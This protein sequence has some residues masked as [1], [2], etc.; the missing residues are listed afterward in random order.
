MAPHCSLWVQCGVFLFCNLLELRDDIFGMLAAIICANTLL[1][2]LDGT[3]NA[4]KGGWYVTGGS[5]AVFRTV[6]Y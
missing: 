4:R 2:F 6:S 1:L 5:G 3:V